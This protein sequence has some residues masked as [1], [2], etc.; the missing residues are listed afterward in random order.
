MAFI[1]NNFNEERKQEK[2]L[3]VVEPDA[4]V[5]GG[6]LAYQWDGISPIGKLGI[7]NVAAPHM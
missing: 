6:L 7:P 3:F 4:S 2:N 1:H 5:S